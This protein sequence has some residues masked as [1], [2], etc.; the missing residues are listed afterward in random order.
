MFGARFDDVPSGESF[1]LADPVGVLAAE[2][3]EDVAAVIVEVSKAAAEGNWVAGYVAYEAAPAFDQS[4]LVRQPR[5]GPL[6]WFGVFGSREM[7]PLAAHDATAIGAYSISQWSPGITREEYREA[8]REIRD[9]IEDGDS[10][11]VNLTFPLRAAFTGIPGVFYN[12][13]VTAQKP[14]Y[15][16]H[17]WHDDRHILSVS[18]ER[19]FSIDDRG[20]TTQPMKGTAP[21]GRWTEEDD[22]YRRFLLGSDKEK[23]ENLMIVDV[24]RSDIGRIA[25]TGSVRVD[26]LFSVEQFRTVWQMTSTITA[27]MR[28]DVGLIDVFEALFP[29]GS[30]TGAPKG[31]SMAIIADVE[32]SGRGVYCGAVGFVPPGDG[33]DGAC[34]NV[35]IRTVEIDDAEGIADYGV[36]GAVTWD[37]DEDAEF[38]EAVTKSEVLRFDVSP[39]DLLESIRWED[40]YRWRDDHLSRM[41]HSAEYWS[42]T[43]DRPAIETMLDDLAGRLDAISKVQ[44]V[45]QANGLVRVASEP[46]SGRWA[47]G[48]GP[49]EE[50]VK[51][52]LDLEP[53]DDRNPRVFHKT[54]DRREFRVR[55]ER[56]PGA[57]DVLFVNRSG[58]VTETSIANIV[59]LFGETWLT[60]PV[61]DGLLRGVMRS[62]L[63]ADG[64]IVERSVTVSEAMRADAIAVVSSVRGWRPA[65]V[66]GTV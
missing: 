4:L 59:L 29:C 54:S 63:L 22:D 58:N 13:L 44:I 56:H 14:S 49:S 11:Q 52:A 24:S 8:F 38:D 30:V 64:T 2:A 35:A 40:G 10:Y 53:I 34:F 1:V 6:A 21:R 23:A 50:P 60:P 65:V 26:A 37:S 19:F 16:S 7:V 62:Q 36:G 12:D 45:A 51:L 42:F 31:S 57:D 48:P 20:I 61:S 32:S 39:M 28:A 9:R 15:A 17:I 66:V 33:L 3:I 55:L 47:S 18:P 5:D 43:F 41:Q 46:L 27:E 25:D